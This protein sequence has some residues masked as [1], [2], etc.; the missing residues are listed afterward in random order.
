MSLHVRSCVQLSQ[1]STKYFYQP[2]AGE[3][4]PGSLQTA[5]HLDA[6]QLE[7]STNLGILLGAPHTWILEISILTF[8]WWKYQGWIKIFRNALVSPRSTTRSG[9]ASYQNKILLAPPPT[10]SISPIPRLYHTWDMFFFE[11]GALIMFQVARITIL[12]QA[13]TKSHQGS[14]KRSPKP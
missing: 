9:C 6:I 5:W 1:S 7:A 12:R 4:A 2:S 11:V 3:Q 10:M 14:Y 13:S 8:I